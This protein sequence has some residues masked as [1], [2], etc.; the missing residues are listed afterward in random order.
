MVQKGML[1]LKD[2]VDVISEECTNTELMLLD[3]M[4]SRNFK[5]CEEAFMYQ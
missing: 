1:I 4:M 5:Y 3:G 2:I